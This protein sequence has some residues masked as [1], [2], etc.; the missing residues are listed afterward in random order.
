MHPPQ[1]QSFHLCVLGWQGL[2]GGGSDSERGGV[3]ILPLPWTPRD[4][5]VGTQLPPAFLPTLPLASLS[6]L[7]DG[8]GAWGGP[9]KP[10]F[11]GSSSAWLHSEPLE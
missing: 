5:Q 9:R 10:F 11:K 1:S 4:P 6:N 7:C 3:E 2:N 8:K